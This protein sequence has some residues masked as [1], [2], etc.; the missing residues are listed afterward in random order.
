M[1]WKSWLKKGFTTTC[2]FSAWAGSI[3]GLCKVFLRLIEHAKRR[4]KRFRLYY[5]LENQWLKLYNKGHKLEDYFEKHAIKKIAIYGM[6]DIG[7]R[8]QEELVHSEKVEISYMIDEQAYRKYG[9][10][11]VV[12]F[13]D[14]W[15]DVDLILITDEFY[16]PEIKEKI[17][18]KGSWKI[19]SLKDVIL[20]ILQYK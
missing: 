8:V 1:K 3:Y 5:L 17:Q 20:E 18:K 9:T 2:I 10:G 7:N 13:E 16:Y 14:T 19:I 11:T 12:D 4:E 6:D 15:E